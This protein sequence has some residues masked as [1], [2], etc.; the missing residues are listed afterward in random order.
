MTTLYGRRILV[1]VAGL[2]IS[3]AR[4]SARVERQADET[5]VTG[6]V[7]I[8]NLTPE[9]AQQIYQRG[10]HVIVQAGYEG[11]FGIIF[12]GPV[13]RV[14]RSRQGLAHITHLRLGDMARA[15]DVL[16]GVSARTYRGPETVRV[17]AQDLVQDMGLAAGPLDA[18][19]QT[20]TVTDYTVGG[21]STEALT[22]LL[23]RVSCRW[24]VDGSLVLFRRAG[25]VTAAA[26][27]VVSPETG[28]V[29]RP[30]ETDDGAEAVQ[31]LNPQVDIDT[32]L[33]LRSQA[34]SGMYRVV[35]VRHEADNW[36]GPFVT[37]TDLRE[38]EG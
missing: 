8:Y 22:V 20:A 33:D 32:V 28:L 19:P 35:G 2:T 16:G 14:V 10:T 13:Q 23:R 37:W 38:L 36:D 27:L 5:Q 11:R 15:P 4:V 26:T 1:D 6:E 34:L 17:I 7:A 21:P 30:R 9:R 25:L 18:I 31:L 12:E 3:R 29:G 24:Y